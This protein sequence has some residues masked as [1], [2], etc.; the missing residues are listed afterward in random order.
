M[1][2]KETLLENN[3]HVIKEAIFYCSD[4]EK[5]LQTHTICCS[6]ISI[7]ACEQREKKKVVDFF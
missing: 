2:N 4:G 7:H 3:V 1:A 6:K 5:M